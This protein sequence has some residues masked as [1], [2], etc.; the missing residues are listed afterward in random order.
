MASTNVKNPP[1]LSNSAS[2]ESW[3]K[4]VKLWKLVTD[5]KAERQGPALVLALSGKAKESVLELTVEQLSSATGVDLI[6]DKLSK[7]YK[8]D[9][10]NVF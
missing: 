4:S 9:T 3:E 7:I 6:I 1:S 5:L 10:G 2:F 8:K